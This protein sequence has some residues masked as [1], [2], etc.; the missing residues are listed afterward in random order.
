[1]CMKEDRQIKEFVTRL[2]LWIFAQRLAE[3]LLWCL[4]AGVLLGAVLELISFWIPWYQ[5]HAWAAGAVLAGCLVA[6]IWALCRYPSAKEA[7]AILD[8]TGLHERTITALELTGDQSFFAALQRKDAW[9]QLSQ[10]VIHKRLPF[11]ISWKRPALLGAMCILL[12]C[13]CLLPSPA[14]K[15]A[16]EQQKVVEKIEKEVEKVQKAEEKAEKTVKEGSEAA[17]YR[18]LMDSIKKEL[19]LADSEEALE[20]TLE[21]SR[22]KLTQLVEKTQKTSVKKQINQLTA[23]LDSQNSNSKD[24][25]QNSQQSLAQQEKSKELAEAAKKAEELLKELQKMENSQELSEEEQKAAEEAAKEALENL[26]EMAEGQN[27]EALAQDLQSAAS[28]LASDSAGSA[29]LASAQATVSAVQAASASA[30]ASNNGQS[31][32]GSANSSAKKGIGKTNSN[33]GTGSGT[34][35]G[36]GS[37][38]GSGSGSGTGAGT[39]TGMGTGSGLGTGWNYGSKDGHEKNIS[40]DSELVSV[41]NGVGEDENLT[42]KNKEGTSYLSKGGDALTWSG[43]AVD[44]EQ[45]VGE[46]SKQALS[47]IE[48]SDYPAGVQDLVK[49][50]FEE[51][52]Q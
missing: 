51:L 4:P 23:A 12:V 31:S 26:A 38:S 34:G 10:V 6:L 14:K 17:E 27:L 20:K 39:G 13:S 48:Q 36:T 50:Y 24:G 28:Q 40:Y 11:S 35:K 18:E 25:Q 42:G 22:K 30:L 19:K 15:Q 1:M 33:S 16:K 43:N 8:Q 52:N 21:R 46:Y 2:R 41:P 29:A 7:A 45:V 32:S 49:S 44:Y 5:V 9:G 3:R 47:E 37:G